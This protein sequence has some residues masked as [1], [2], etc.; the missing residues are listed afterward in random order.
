MRFGIRYGLTL[1][2]IVILCGCKKEAPYIDFVVGNYKVSGALQAGAFTR[3][4]TD[5]L[6]AIKKVD[7]WTIQF[8]R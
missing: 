2:T 5:S 6:V 1:M 4:I 8:Y 3:S 7:D